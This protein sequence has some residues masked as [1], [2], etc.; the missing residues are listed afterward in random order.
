[1]DLEGIEYIQGGSAA[2]NI[3]SILSSVTSEALETI[4]LLVDIYLNEEEDLDSDS[5]DFE[6]LA[7]VLRVK[8]GL[9]SFRP[10]SFTLSTA[11][12]PEVHED[13]LFFCLYRKKL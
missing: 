12:M 4:D 6:E 11:Y 9:S 10:S 5:V 7:S 13:A 8:Y 2:G 3:A 1:M